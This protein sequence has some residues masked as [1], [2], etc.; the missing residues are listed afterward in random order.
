MLRIL[1][2]VIALY[3]LSFCTAL[4]RQQ[5]IQQNDRAVIRPSAIQ[6]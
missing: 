4:D 3:W 6:H 2:L 5:E 1:Y